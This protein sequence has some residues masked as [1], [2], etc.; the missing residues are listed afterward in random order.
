[1]HTVQTQELQDLIDLGRDA[2]DILWEMAALQEET[3]GTK[4]VLDN[5]KV[6]QVGLQILTFHPLIDCL[7]P[8]HFKPNLVSPFMGFLESFKASKEVCMVTRVHAPTFLPGLLR[9]G[10]HFSNN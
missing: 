2:A 1:M 8:I 5:V 4:D 9:S 10:R 3:V 6:L 7:V